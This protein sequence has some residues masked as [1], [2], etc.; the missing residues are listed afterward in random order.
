MTDDEIEGAIA[1]CG[2]GMPALIEA[3]FQPY[4]LWINMAVQCGLTSAEAPLARAYIK[5]FYDPEGRM[6]TRPSDL[7]GLPEHGRAAVRS[8]RP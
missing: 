6:R 3:A 1:R 5:A 7:I 2:A 4:A 8:Q